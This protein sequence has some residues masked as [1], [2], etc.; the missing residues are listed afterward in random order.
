MCS[1][2][3]KEAKTN[4]KEKKMTGELCPHC[5]TPLKECQNGLICPNHG[6]I[7]DYNQEKETDD[8][9]RSYLG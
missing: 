4:S 8:K 9:N 2:K 6:L 5:G 7:I 3:K 1:K